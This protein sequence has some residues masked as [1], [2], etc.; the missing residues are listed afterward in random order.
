MEEL[1]IGSFNLRNHYWK[2]GWDG[3][4]YPLLLANFIKINYINLLGV[5]ELVR[6]YSY[7]LQKELGESYTITGKY[8][9]G[10]IPFIGQF[11]ESNS[12]ISNEP[13]LQ[14]E[15]KYLARIPLIHTQ[16]PRIM[17]SIETLDHFMI[18]THL[19][20]WNQS[21][22]KYQLQ[23][24]YNYIV[25]NKN[26]FPIIT[27]D[28]NMDTSKDYFLEFIKALEK[29][30][31]QYIDNKTPTYNPKEQ[32]LDHIFIPDNYQIDDI[33]IIQD[34]PINEIS[35]HCPIIVKARKK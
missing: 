7:K 28:F 4:H 12:I 3:D 17:T 5:Q 25:K 29:L 1:K 15:T 32:V 13:I 9:Y 23:V 19:E 2:K 18:N 34:Q 24:L 27:G 21:S 11:N 16:M 14:S 33:E 22:Q 31:I 8:R 20:Y 26:K 6:N 35:D 10:H 30:G